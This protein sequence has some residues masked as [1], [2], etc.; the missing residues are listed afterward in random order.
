MV[1]RNEAKTIERSLASIR[2]FCKE[3]VVVDTGSTDDTYAI[4]S[5]YADRVCTYTGCNDEHGR[6]RDFSDA[7]NHAWSLLTQPWAMW[8]DGDD[9]VENG[10]SIQPFLDEFSKH[11]NPVAIVVP[12]DYA[13]DERGNVTCTLYRERI[14]SPRSAFLWIDPVHESLSPQTTDYESA[15]VQQIRITHLRFKTHKAI[16]PYRNFRILQKEYEK[17]GE[18]NPRI[19]YYLGLE[20]GNLGEV[21][22]CIET[23][24][25]YI[26]IS[27][28]EDEQCMAMLT[29]ATHHTNHGNYQAAVNLA[30]RAIATKESWPEGYLSLAL[31]NYYIGQ[32]TGSKRAYQRCVH[33]ARLGLSVTPPLNLLF[34][35]PQD[36]SVTVYRYLA[37]ALIQLD[38]RDEAMAALEIGLKNSPG[39]VHFLEQRRRLLG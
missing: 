29:M 6:I 17:V 19:L 8:L 38:R 2:P 31:A 24:T 37:E 33:F 25:R 10:A 7:R 13:H 11:K 3:L 28:W 5:Q 32:S 14:V 16:D 4:A 27:T 35:N 36:R 39:D 23:L 9:V 15:I 1:V 22:K 18:S 34:V 20:Y 12:Y 21:E 30:L 26:D